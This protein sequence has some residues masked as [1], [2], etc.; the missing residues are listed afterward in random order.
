MVKTVNKMSV[1]GTYLGLMAIYWQAYS[2]H[3]T[4]WWKA[5]S[6]PL[7]SGTKPGNLVLPLLFNIVQKVLAR[8]VRQ[9]KEIKCMQ[10]WKEEVKLSLCAE[11]ILC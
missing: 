5:K 4:R 8:A 10:I 3:R 2:W 1:A 9:E 11:D 6:F 7:I